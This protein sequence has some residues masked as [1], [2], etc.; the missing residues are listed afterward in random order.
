MR[1]MHRICTQHTML[2]LLANIAINTFV[3]HEI[4]T[5][6]TKCIVSFFCDLVGC[7]GYCAASVCRNV[8]V[9]CPRCSLLE[10]PVCTRNDYSLNAI[11]SLVWLWEA[12]LRSAANGT[13]Q[14]WKQIPVVHART[15]EDP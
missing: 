3:T 11:C 9:D 12:M 2:E 7:S 5:E 6:H 10:P 14:E 15:E 8:Q 4:E 1:D 13:L